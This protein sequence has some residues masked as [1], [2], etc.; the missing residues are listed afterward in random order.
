MSGSFRV[1]V[2]RLHEAGKIAGPAEC[3]AFTILPIFAEGKF[4]PDNMF[5]APIQEVFVG[6]ADVHKQIAELPDGSQV[7]IKTVD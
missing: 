6:L 2:G 3:Y 5:V 4:V 7:Q 1:W